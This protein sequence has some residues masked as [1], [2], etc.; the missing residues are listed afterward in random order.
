[1]SEPADRSR[2]ENME[3]VS[4][5]A[6]GQ[7]GPKGDK[8]DQ[9]EEGKR[10]DLPPRLRRALVVLFAVAAALA[11]V[12][13]LATLRAQDADR[14]AQQRQGRVLERELCTT[15]RKAAALKAP[16]GNPAKNPSRAY[17]QGE[18]LVWTGVL[19]D[20]KCGQLSGN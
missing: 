8:G 16:A 10:G 18:H 6:R 17:L 19:A 20:L 7:R 12:A 4:G 15:F 14:A 3:Q 13:L 2:A 1:M 11:L 5:I 9:G